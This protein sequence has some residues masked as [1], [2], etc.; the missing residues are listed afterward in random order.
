MDCNYKTWGAANQKYISHRVLVSDGLSL[1]T[2]LLDHLSVCPKLLYLTCGFLFSVPE[3][4]NNLVFTLLAPGRE[5][6]QNINPIRALRGSI[7][8]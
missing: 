2:K 1:R 6:L 5:V 4:D 3:K 8:D 7:I